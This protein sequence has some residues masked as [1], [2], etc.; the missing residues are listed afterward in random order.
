MMCLLMNKTLFT[1]RTQSANMYKATRPKLIFILK[2][3][4]TRNEKGK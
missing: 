2:E 3:M 4:C 1:Q